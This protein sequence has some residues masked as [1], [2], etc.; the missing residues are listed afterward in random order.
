MLINAFWSNPCDRTT[1][2]KRTRSSLTGSMCPRIRLQ[3]AASTPAT[4]CSASILRPAG[5]SGS[6]GSLRRRPPGRRSNHRFGRS[7]PG[8]DQARRRRGGLL[9]RRVAVSRQGLLGFTALPLRHAAASSAILVPRVGVRAGACVPGTSQSTRS[10][11][12]YPRAAALRRRGARGHAR[13]LTGRRLRCPGQG[14]KL[15]GDLAL[16]RDGGVLRPRRRNRVRAHVGLG[17]RLRTRRFFP[18]AAPGGVDGR[19]Y[20]P[21]GT[22]GNGARGTTLLR[23]EARLGKVRVFLEPGGPRAIAHASV[24]RGVLMLTRTDLIREATATG[25]QAEPL[26]KV[27]RLLGL[28]DALRSHPFLKTRIALKGGTALNL[29]ASDVPR[30]SVD[31][32]LNYLGAAKME[33]MQADRPKVEQAV[34]A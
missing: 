33:T 2:L 22:Q 15:G 34:Q 27:I 21:C 28:L 25:F 10:R 7:V 4:V 18:G 11:R 30:L 17:H 19:G 9:S 3:G 29:F 23:P 5:C 31:I 14:R 8:S 24:G 13:T 32:D 26:E 20:A 6:G 16:A 12:R 1:F